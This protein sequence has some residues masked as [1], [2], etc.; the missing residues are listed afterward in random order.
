VQLQVD[1]NLQF[2]LR[3]RQRG[4]SAAMTQTFP[5][6][7]VL[8]APHMRAQRPADRK[9]LTPPRPPQTRQRQAVFI[10]ELSRIKVLG[11]IGRRQPQL[12]GLH[13]NSRLHRFTPHVH[14]CPL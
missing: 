14:G 9:L 6:R 5:D 13:H 7:G 12:Q 1:A 11:G 3:L 10:R 4:V 8:D 2:G